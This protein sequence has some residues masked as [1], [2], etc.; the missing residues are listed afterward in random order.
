MVGRVWTSGDA[1]WIEDVLNETDEPRIVPALRSGLRT[2][3]EVPIMAGGRVY[4]VLEYFGT[5]IRR[6]DEHMLLRLYDLGRKLGHR[7]QAR[8]SSRRSQPSASREHRTPH[9]QRAEQDRDFAETSKSAAKS[10]AYSR[11]AAKPR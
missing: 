6:E 9:L 2:A 7:A 4:G 10:V 8:R 1:A 11:I 5:G 3:V